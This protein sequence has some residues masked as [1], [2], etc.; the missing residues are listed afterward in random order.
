[1]QAQLID[2]EPSQGAVVS[3]NMKYWDLYLSTSKYECKCRYYTITFQDLKEQLKKDY[4][5]ADNSYVTK[6]FMAYENEIRSE[7]YIYPLCQNTSA[8]VDKC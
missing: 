2:H 4:L 6:H 7:N 8:N 3:W 1:M 5:Q